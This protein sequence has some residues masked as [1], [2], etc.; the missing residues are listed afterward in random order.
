MVKRRPGRPSKYT[1]ELAASICRRIADG[2]SL[3]SI[4]GSKGMPSRYAV[5]R[6]QSESSEFRTQYVTARDAM[7]DALAEEALHLAKTATAANALARRLYVDTIKW[8]VGKV[9]PKKYGDKLDLNVAGKV[10]V[11]DAI[12]EGRKRLA[13]IRDGRSSAA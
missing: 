4:C 9:A 11:G 2:E 7:V 8:Y 3:R 13:R 1:P 12:E 6:W 10:T 5:L